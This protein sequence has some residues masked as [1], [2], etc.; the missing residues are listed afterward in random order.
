MDYME[1]LKIII[2]GTIGTIGFSLLFK[3]N[4]RR[5]GFNALGGMITCIVYVVASEI[6]DQEFLQNFFP[7]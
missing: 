5:T 3:S 1:A 6:F 2:S 7:A 4:P